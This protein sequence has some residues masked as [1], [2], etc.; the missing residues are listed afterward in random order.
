MLALGNNKLTPR[1]RLDKAAVAITGRPYYRHL[2]GILMVGNRSIKEGIPTACTNGRDE[3][4]GPEFVESLTDA[5]LRFVVIH[6]TY[7]KLYRHLTTWANLNKI[8]PRKA[9]QAMDYV[10]NLQ[11]RDEN[12]DGFAVCPLAV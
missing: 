2:S 4:Y 10:I 5:E 1:Q 6:E 12:K 7:H 3:W 11:I 9:N 8:N